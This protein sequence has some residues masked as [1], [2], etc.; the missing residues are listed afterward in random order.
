MIG[1]VGYLLLLLTVCQLRQLFDRGAIE[2]IV[3]QFFLSELDDFRSALAERGYGVAPMAMD[4]GLWRRQRRTYRRSLIFPTILGTLAFLTQELSGANPW[5]IA[6]ALS[7]YI[8]CAL[9]MSGVA[10]RTRGYD[11]G[12]GNRDPKEWSLLIPAIAIR[13]MISTV[14]F[15]VAYRGIS[16][17]NDGRP[18]SGLVGMMVSIVVLGCAHL[19]VLAAE[20]VV[21]RLRKGTF[22]EATPEDSTLYLRTFSDDKIRTL[23]WVAGV[24]PSAPQITLFR[25]RFEEQISY[26]L[27]GEGPL[28][29]I[30]RPGERVPELGA[31]RTYWA[32]ADWQ[33]AVETTAHRVHRVVMVAGLTGG[34]AWEIERLREWGMLN[35][36]LIVVPPD[37][38]ARTHQ[39]L[40]KVVADLGLADFPFD[41]YA[42]AFVTGIGF[43]STGAPVVY[44]A[45][46]R[47]ILSYWSTLMMHNGFLSGRWRLKETGGQPRVVP[48]PPLD[49]SG[50]KSEDATAS[51][52]P[53]L[54]EDADIVHAPGDRSA[55][56]VTSMFD[57]LNLNTHRAIRGARVVA[58]REKVDSVGELQLLAG[59]IGVLPAWVLAEL[60][61]DACSELKSRIQA[62][63]PSDGGAA[64]PPAFTPKTRDVL[65]RAMNI[66]DAR[67][68]RAI[69]AL[70]VLLALAKDL[71]SAAGKLLADNGVEPT[72]VESL[73][74]SANFAHLQG[75]AQWPSREEHARAQGASA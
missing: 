53:S 57:R 22:S 37:S 73:L 23:S 68:H 21:R 24:G 74:S 29:A 17:L 13:I 6:A 19:P 72:R 56:P 25:S 67:G 33:T 55:D 49:A 15:V 46:G 11:S 48:V 28:V 34:L 44:V 36:A 5:V 31:T 14:G 50:S 26:A 58:V 1:L 12:D 20:R 61:T 75:E 10:F 51:T 66:A 59:V 32:D 64:E 4:G 65:Q 2:R 70:H 27:L 43:D 60:G 45:P 40:R 3:A 39:R 16:L 9:A 62:T 63:S 38:I 35:K 52:P 69:D 54:D 30:G 42:A 18:G 41:G 8:A 71:E 7:S 47:H